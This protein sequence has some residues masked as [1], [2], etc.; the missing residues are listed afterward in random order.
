MFNKC[1]FVILGLTL[2]VTSVGCCCL[3][4]YGYG[5]GYG[6]RCAPC[7]NGCAPQGGTYYPPAQSFYQGGATQTAYATDFSQG[8]FAPTA[9]AFVPTTM[10]MAPAPIQGPPIYNTAV[11][12][13]ATLPMY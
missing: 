11:I 8:G 1:A 10:A 12:P 5:S 3:G 7:N 6:N 13:T 9:S 2:T 4:G